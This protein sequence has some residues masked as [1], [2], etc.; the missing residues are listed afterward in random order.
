MYWALGY[1]KSPALP[2]RRPMWA[3]R[4]QAHPMKRT[5]CFFNEPKLRSIS[6]FLIN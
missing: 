1:V 5:R 2:I 3:S 4:L 6:F